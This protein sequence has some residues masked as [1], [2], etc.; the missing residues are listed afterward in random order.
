MPASGVRASWDFPRSVDASRHVLETAAAHGV[1]A[2]SILAGTGLTEAQLA[3][4]AVEVQAGQELAIVRN[5]LRHVD[6]PTGLG[7]ETGLRYNLANTGILGYAFL[8]SPTMRDAL[9]IGLRYAA[10]SSTFL[11]ITVHESVPGLALELD[12]SQIP[13]DVRQFLVERDLAAIVHIAPLLIGGKGSG[14]AVKVE[15]H[16]TEFPPELLTATGLP[17]TLDADAPRTALTFPG[18]LLDQPMPAADPATAAMCV[19]QCEALLERRRHR[20]GLAAQL[21]T[22]LLSDPAHIPAM[23]AIARELGVTDRTLHRRLAAE[24]T[25]YRALVDEVRE[26]LA[27]ELLGNHFTVEEVA[28][29]LG[30]SETAGFTHAFIRWRGYPPSQLSRR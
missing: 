7:L 9:A 1:D 10:L 5:L 6:D 22:R 13:S 16:A 3:D 26:A 14:A 21:R 11:D 24:N 30:Y 27:V 17:F 19:A 25:S 18:E 2:P 8:T 15:L 28:R 12:S 29:R 23:V 4:P 20:G